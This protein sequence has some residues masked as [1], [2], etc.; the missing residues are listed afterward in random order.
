MPKACRSPGRRLPARLP[1]PGKPWGLLLWAL[2]GDG[3][4]WGALLWCLWPWG[5]PL[6]AAAQ[7]S[8][9]GLWPRT[10]A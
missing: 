4:Y 10:A 7:G 1:L 8:L 6:W 3:A 2:G 5:L 9:F